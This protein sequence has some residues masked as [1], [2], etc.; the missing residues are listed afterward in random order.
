[1]LKNKIKTAYFI[2]IKGVG[3][4]MLAQF[5][6]NQGVRVSG[7][8]I[9]E[10]FMTDEILKQSGIK[11][12]ERFKASNLNK[13][14]DMIIY[15]TA[16]NPQ[17]NPELKAALKQKKIPVKTYAEA[18]AEVFN[19]YRGI[20]VIGSHGKTTVSAWLGYILKSANFKPNV[21]VGARVPQFKGSSLIGNSEYL[22]SEV[23]EY[24]NKLKYFKPF[25]VVLNNVDW[26]HHDYFKTKEQY[27]QVFARFVA[28]IPKDGFLVFNYDDKDCRR[29]AKLTKAKTIGFSLNK[30]KDYK[31]T[32]WQV[33]KMDYK[34]GQRIFSIE[35]EKTVKDLSINLL[36][37]YNLANGLAAL[38]A[39]V[40]LGVSMDK[41]RVGLARF[42]GTARRQEI[43]G[44]YRG[45]VIID[46]Y[47]HHPTEISKT[48]QALR[49]KYKTEK[50]T[51]V[52]HPHTFTRTKALL[53]E[54]SQS[55]PLA[56]E[57]LV[58]DIYG[59]A[60]EVAGG[61]SS[62]DLV[63]GVV[64]FNRRKKIEQV[65]SVIGSLN[66]ATTHLKTTATK[67]QVIIL[68][69]AGDVFRVGESL[70]SL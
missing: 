16:Y 41:V 23:D 29:L 51:V 36:G 24:Q 67:N 35:N 45:A 55:F 4:T 6:A 34:K 10:T 18:L 46:D 68:M 13:L 3:M 40:E 5:L 37:E 26:D 52:F 63:N 69:G 58:L 27:Y 49:E 9:N 2:G 57:V 64:K 25:G 44:R 30:I 17:T 20:A 70:L 1:M 50:L 42:K 47:A 54:F 28:R 11:V 56:D 12:T 22:V 59:S 48:V 66:D 31:Q 53:K 39:A 21:L 61:V 38:A 43:L 60:R 32:L 19:N 14:A 7:S 62:Q 33:K 15:S 65:V 8:D